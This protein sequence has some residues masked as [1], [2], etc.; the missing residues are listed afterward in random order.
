MMHLVSLHGFLGSPA[1]WGQVLPMGESQPTSLLGGIHHHGLGAPFHGLPANHAHC[2]SWEHALDLM[3]AEL[4]EGPL[5]LL[6]YSLGARLTLGLT[7]RLGSRVR[8]AVLVSGHAGLAQ[9][10]ERAARITFDE[11]MAQKLETSATMA[12][13]VDDWERLPLFSTQSSLPAAA[14]Q[15]QRRTRE[16][17]E[18]RVVAGAFRILGTGSMPDYESKL[19]TFDAPLL[20]VTGELDPKYGELASRYAHAAARGRHAVIAGCGHN[21]LLEAP[22]KLRDLVLESLVQTQRAA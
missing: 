2:T 9:R 6:G 18:P 12:A 5:V 19:A 13:F 1:A 16:R 7:H 22:E 4:P 15:A 10:D 20:F 11:N 17:H 8:A 3:S 14:L 21:P